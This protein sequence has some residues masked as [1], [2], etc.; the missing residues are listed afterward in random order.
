M[1]FELKLDVTTSADC[2]NLV[3]IE[4]S[5]LYNSVS[6]PGGWGLQSMSSQG[7]VLQIAVQPFIPL[8]INSEGE[9]KTINPL[10]LYN[11]DQ[12]DYSNFQESFDIKNLKISIPFSQL[13]LD[14]YNAI[15][16]SWISLGLTTVE[17]DFVLNNLTEWTSI[18]DHVYYVHATI[19]NPVTGDN[20]GYTETGVHNTFKHNSVCNIE[21]RI[22]DFLTQIDLR[23]EDCDDEDIADAALYNALLHT[24]KNA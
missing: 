4:N 15:E 11:S 16:T 22:N 14:F 3:M 2:A 17:K 12:A 8:I 5:G 13:Y 9:T 21:H 24:L 7:K 1:A 18:P 20:V 23:C 19:L 10:L 6:N